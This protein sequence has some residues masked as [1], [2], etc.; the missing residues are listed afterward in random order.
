MPTSDVTAI[1]VASGDAPH[2]P[3]ARGVRSRPIDCFYLYPGRA[4]TS[5]ATPTSTAG[6]EREAG[7]RDR[8]RVAVR[9]RVPRL[10][11]PCTVSASAR[12]AAIGWPTATCARR[13]ATTSR[14]Y[15]HGRGVVLIGHSQGA[16]MLA[17]ADPRARS[18]HARRRAR[19]A[20]LGDPA[21]RQR[22]RRAGLRQGRLV[23]AR[24]RLH[25]RPI[26]PAASSPTTRGTGR[27]RAAR[28]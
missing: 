13:G 8:R 27:R 20:R 9:P 19:A 22:H 7:R 15:N 5:A 3:R 2:R 10:S 26:R 17:P 1:S 4:A 6:Q 23:R 16:V 28:P 21:R 18:S 11:R 12:V 14:T 25:A 24:A